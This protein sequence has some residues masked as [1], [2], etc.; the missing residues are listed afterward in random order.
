LKKF[1]KLINKKSILYFLGFLLTTIET[2]L[3]LSG[4][5]L[6]QTEG[7]RI[8]ESFVKGGDIVLLVSGIIL[9][10]ALF[11]VSFK[12]KQGNSKVYTYIHSSI[13]IV[14]LSVEG[15]FLGFQTFI[16]QE[17]CVFCLTVFSILFV[18][19]II[20]LKQGK[21]E[22]IFAF[23]CFSAVFFATYLVSPQIA[24]LPLSQHVLVYSKNCPHCKEVIQFCKQ[25]S[26]PVETFESDKIKAT[27]KSL[28]INSV[29]VLFCNEGTE[30]KIIMG[31][32][33][34][35][36]YLFAKINS[37]VNPTLNQDTNDIKQPIQE[38]QKIKINIKQ[39]EST[40]QEQQEDNTNQQPQNGVC[41]IFKS[42]NPIFKSEKSG[43]CN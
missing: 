29:P 43:G 41:P 3:H 10:T 23:V 30:K 13:L 1:N 14:A 27:L 11:F 22:L 42:E 7:C 17:F 39:K 20:R 9:F 34:I 2:I 18:S 36:E 25:Y 26:I 15:Y 4:E 19:C 35:K 32:D 37:T 16:V 5:S 21:K 31:T 28:N 8:V 24:T 12:E 40:K 6:C 38:K 33:N